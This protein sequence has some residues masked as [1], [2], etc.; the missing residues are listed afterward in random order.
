MFVKYL[1]AGFLLVYALTMMVQ[2]MS[3]FLNNVAILLREPD[4]EPPVAE[5][6]SL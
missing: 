5:A 6:Q 1:L 4:A 3:S 2:F